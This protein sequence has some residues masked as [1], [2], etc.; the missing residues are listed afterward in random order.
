MENISNKKPQIAFFGTDDFSI[1]ILEQLEI[2]Q[3]LPK[4]IITAP[5]KPQGRKMIPTEPVVKIWADERSIPTVQPVNPKTESALILK[6][7]EEEG[8]DL[9]IV[10]SYG[11][12]IPKEVVEYPK[13]KTLN[14]HPSLL[15]DLR[16]PSPIQNTIIKREYAGVTIMKMDEKMD[17]GPL[18]SQK[19]INLEEEKIIWPPDYYELEKILANEGGKLLC[20]VIKP[21]IKGET[22]T[23]E[24]DHNIATYTK[25]IKKLD[26]EINLS[27]SPEE[28]FR[29]I[30]AYKKWPRAF[31][32]LERKGQKIR[33]I[34]TEAKIV[35]NKLVI[36]KVIP[37]GRKEIPFQDL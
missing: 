3:L 28:N 14:V 11:Y 18:L 30:Q 34:V 15:P 31:F 6:R 32:F 4:I 19:K 12:I 13:N 10:A 25:L 2:A 8:I 37:E 1:K 36:S 21:W 17:H 20:S 24:Q 29:K 22:K 27:D 9:S 35:S 26:A 5:K 16:G 7:M 23:K 33:V